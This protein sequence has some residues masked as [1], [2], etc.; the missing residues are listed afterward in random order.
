MSP[1]SPAVSFCAS[2]STQLQGVVDGVG[3][4]VGVLVGVGVG[5]SAAQASQ[6]AKVL[7]MSFVF[8]LGTISDTK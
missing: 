6:D 1:L 4:S 8:V 7:I 5:M 3:V 2:N